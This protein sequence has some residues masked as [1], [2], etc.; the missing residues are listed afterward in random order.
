MSDQEKTTSEVSQKNPRRTFF[1]VCFACMGTAAAA[2][3]VY[4]V[5]GFLQL[6]RRFEAGEALQVPETDIVEGQAL[7]REHN[8]QQVILIR[9]NGVIYVFNA[10]CPHLGCL[11]TWD[12]VGRVFRCPC[13]GAVF[14]EG[15]GPV[16]GPVN[17]PLPRM[18][19]TNK[20]GTIVLS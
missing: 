7:Y 5:A 9:V 1:Q 15:G 10:S 8:G 13:H 6:P 16:H 20:E 19:Y 14:D 12:P 18:E 3:V 2:A 11:V 4:P 17:Q